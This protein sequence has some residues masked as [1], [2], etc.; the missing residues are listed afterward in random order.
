M[1]SIGVSRVFFR[2]IAE[3]LSE[4]RAFRLL[5]KGVIPL[6][7]RPLAVELFAFQNIVFV[8]KKYKPD[9]DMNPTIEIADS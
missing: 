1:N 9:H 6:G 5:P 8:H 2:D 7:K 3:I 4:Y